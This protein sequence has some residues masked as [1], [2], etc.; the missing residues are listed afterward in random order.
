MKKTSSFLIASLLFCIA[1]VGGTFQP[2]TV[3]VVDTIAD[4]TARLPSRLYPFVD[5]SRFDESQGPWIVPRRARY[6]AAA[7]DTV[8]RG[9]IYEARGGGRWV[10][11]DCLNG[12]EV[13]LTTFGTVP[14]VV[15]P[16]APL[17]TASAIVRDSTDALQ[18]AVD[19]IAARGG[20]VLTLPAG[21]F[22]VTRSIVLGPNVHIKG[23]MPVTLGQIDLGTTNSLN[24]QLTWIIGQITATNINGNWN[25][26]GFPVFV[27]Q[28]RAGVYTNAFQTSFINYAG[29]TVK[30]SRGGSIIENVAILPA[31]GWAWNGGPPSCAWFI[32]EVANCEF[33]SSAAVGSVGPGIYMRGP[34]AMKVTDSFISENWVGGVFLTDFSDLDMRGTRVVGN[35]GFGLGLYK[36]N[37]HYFV[38]NDFWNPKPDLVTFT[39]GTIQPVT[40]Y[41]NHTWV[42]NELVERAGWTANPTNDTLNPAIGSD[43]GMPIMFSGTDLPGGLLPNTI[44]FV[45]VSDITGAN[46]KVYRSAGDALGYSGA[47]AID[48]TSPG[49]NWKAVS[50]FAASAFWAKDAEEIFIKGARSDMTYHIGAVLDTVK[51]GKIEGWDSWDQGRNQKLLGS[52]LPGVNDIIGIYLTNCVGISLVD[53]FLSAGKDF[54]G[55][56]VGGLLPVVYTGIRLD[57]S[58][59]IGITGNQFDRLHN[60]ILVDQDSTFTPVDPRWAN[61]VSPWTTRPVNSLSTVNPSA[62]NGVQLNKTNL[63]YGT[64][65]SGST[66]FVAFSVASKIRL[67]SN[68]SSNTQEGIWA[69]SSGNT[70]TAPSVKTPN[71]VVLVQY[72]DGPTA[73]QYLYLRFF[74]AATTDWRDY[75]CDITEYAGRDI[76]VV[77]QRDSAG[78]VQIYVEGISRSVGTGTVG[79]SPPSITNTVYAPYFVVG[80]WDAALNYHRAEWFYGAAVTIGSS[81]TYDGIARLKHWASSPATKVI[82]DFDG[83]G[84]YGVWDKSGNGVTGQLADLSASRTPVW[85]NDPFAVTVFDSLGAPIEKLGPRSFKLPVGGGGGGSTVSVDGTVA[86]SLNFADATKISVTKSG[87]NTT[88]NINAGTVPFSDMTN[89]FAS[90]FHLRGTL[91]SRPAASAA[92]NGFLYFVT[93]DSS[94]Y[95]SD[96]SVWALWSISTAGGTTLPTNGASPG[97]VYTLQQDLTIKPTNS[98]T[99]SSMTIS[100]DLTVGGTIVPTTPIPLSSIAPEA[101]SEGEASLVYQPLD[102]EDDLTAI[103]G[104]SGTGLVRRL[105]PGAFIITTLPGDTNLFY[106]GDGTF[107]APPAGSGSGTG[108]VTAVTSDFQVN[109]GTLSLSNTPV[110]AGTYPYA[111]IGV[112]AKGRVTSI[113]SNTPPGGMVWDVDLDFDLTNTTG[114]FVP[115]YTNAVPLGTTRLLTFDILAG[116]DT[117][118][119]SWRVLGRLSNRSSGVM[120]ANWIHPEGGSTDTN[121][122]AYLTNSG[123]NLVLM[124]RGPS[125]QPQRG[126]VR[127]WI[128]TVTNAGVYTFTPTLDTNGLLLVWRLDEA[129]TGNR[130][131]DDANAL[132]LTQTNTVNFVTSG[133][134]SNAARFSRASSQSLGRST[135]NLLEVS[136]NLNFTL[137]AWVNPSSFPSSGQIFGIA[138]KCDPGVNARVEYALNMRYNAANQFQFDFLTG[139]NGAG[140]GTHTIVSSVL[141]TTTNTWYMLAA[142]RDAL[143]GSNW[144]SVNGSPKEYVASP[145][146]GPTISEFRVGLFGSATHFFNGLIDEIT[147][148]RTN[149][150]ASQIS[151]M[152]NNPPPT[153]P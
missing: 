106:R 105:G 113:S 103:G 97:W 140:S 8:W 60:G 90:S 94:V 17:T 112:D 89:G 135:T 52:R 22:K 121:S 25:G 67:N 37:T 123:T 58:V 54:T 114:S 146:P 19:L 71:S 34:F 148:W 48:I 78:A 53:N 45:R 120:S 117:N 76:E 95:R 18:A 93:D 1:A 66:S 6:D 111:T 32:N 87:S 46:W 82:W 151:F 42:Y 7:T 139:T 3:P 41:T 38:G 5:V 133:V 100:G 56:G 11:D 136:S 124:V 16:V 26:G 125:Y 110:T 127:G 2:A 126:N 59:D 115:I 44:Y 153:L 122:G 88:F 144:I 99:F 149:L 129:T 62:W 91:A 70:L 64:L 50:P 147:F 33:R 29:E 128:K 55:G 73:G 109:S 35:K 108:L 47:P 130:T 12:A 107:A 61:T 20:G 27:S 138:G 30:Y 81:F 4:L 14:Q 141:G 150:T 77:A 137:T 96:G 152:T 24:G 131:S 145:G 104:L 69:L 43:T 31:Y 28:G 15:G 40:T 72:F 21:M 86:S 57:D 142:G 79:G 68:L 143:V 92:N 63:I 84:S 39:G 23:A 9:C 51:R 36:A 118:A 101:L 49:T 134:R 119:Q 80:A 65:P 74:G 116:G 13:D 132:V 83:A 102:P 10:F 98:V 85:G 75:Y